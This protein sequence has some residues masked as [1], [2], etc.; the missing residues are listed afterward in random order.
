MKTIAF[1]LLIVNSTSELISQEL[2]PPDTLVPPLILWQHS[3]VGALGVTQ[4]SYNDWAQ[5]GE[6]NFSYNMNVQGKSVYE[7][8]TLLWSNSY[9]FSFGQT[10]I[11]D[12]DLRKN[13]DRIELESVGTWKLG[14]YI[15]PY[16]AATLKTQFA[17]GYQYDAKG[18]A[19]A[20]SKFFDPGYLTQSIGT[21]YQLIPAVRTR[22]GAALREI[23]TSEFTR[24]SDDPQTPEVEKVKVEDGLESVTDL[25]WKIDENVLLT[26]K[27]EL[28]SSFR[29]P[30][31]VVVRSDNSITTRIGKIITLFVEV[32][33]VIDHIVCPRTQVKQTFGIG[34]NYALL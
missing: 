7:D 32:Q 6:N 2:Q 26:S 23:M 33:I 17:L 24:Y 19:T 11:G 18:N 3:V 31:N 27:L 28:F 22:V 14:S 15:N 20:V 29:K 8:I 25:Q 9:K 1:L 5:G 34:L 10:K 4:V 16:V 30:E 12:Q 13:D 21:G